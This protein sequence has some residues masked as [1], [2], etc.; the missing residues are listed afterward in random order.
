[1]TFWSI[2]QPLLG[3][4]YSTE[5][6]KIKSNMVLNTAVLYSNNMYIILGRFKHRP[7]C[8]IPGLVVHLHVYFYVRCLPR[9][10]DKSVLLSMHIW[11]KTEKLLDMYLYLV[12]EWPHTGQDQRWGD[13]ERAHSR[14]T[15]DMVSVT[16]SIRDPVAWKIYSLMT[17]IRYGSKVKTI[18]Y[19]T[20][21]C[22]RFKEAWWRLI[23]KLHRDI[24][25]L[26][27]NLHGRGR[28]G[29][30]LSVSLLIS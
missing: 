11:C 14:Y 28:T 3:Q 6:E 16:F 18:F 2:T 10:A 13:Q 25:L 1:M 24:S 15:P 9:R 23:D 30:I 17:A 20:V 19:L 4:K 27:N 12:S 26:Q 5:T 29:M 8:H 7:S 21:K 22:L